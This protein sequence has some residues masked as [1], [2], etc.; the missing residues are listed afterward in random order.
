VSRSTTPVV[1]PA[2]TMSPT[3]IAFSSWMKTPV[4]T[5]CTSFCAPKPMASPMTPADAISGPMLSPS[6][7]SANISVITRSAIVAAFRRS[8]RSVCS[9]AVGTVPKSGLSRYS[10]HEV[11]ASQRRKAAARIA[12]TERS[13]PARR[14][15]LGV[16]SQAPRSTAP[17][18]PERGRSTAITTATRSTTRSCGTKPFRRGSSRGSRAFT[19]AGS[20]TPRPTAGRARR[21]GRSRA[22]AAAQRQRQPRGA[23]H[24]LLAAGEHGDEEPAEPEQ[25]RPVPVPRER[26]VDAPGLGFLGQMGLPAASRSITTVPVSASV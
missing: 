20:D 13:V 9:R 4:M 19:V 24:R 10:T 23:V 5:S 6:S 21:T 14:G 16:A 7:E 26:R 8:V 22:D 2:V 3:F 18:E 25:R 15:P 12:V 11:S 17:P 1:V